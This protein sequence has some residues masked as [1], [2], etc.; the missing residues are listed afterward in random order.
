VKGG[1]TYGA[2]GGDAMGFAINVDRVDAVLLVDGWH[3]V[4]WKDGKSTFTR[5]TYDFVDDRPGVSPGR[6]GDDPEGA[7]WREGE[8]LIYCPARSIQAVRISP[9]EPPSP[10]AVGFGR[11]AISLDDES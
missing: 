1:L 4:V 3:T 7:S 11:R 6:R 8:N 10:P 5:D 2:E 9:Q